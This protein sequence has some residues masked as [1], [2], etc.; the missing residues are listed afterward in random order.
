MFVAQLKKSLQLDLSWAL[1][2]DPR[3]RKKVL[4]LE[5][6]KIGNKQV[7]EEIKKIFI[8]CYESYESH[9]LG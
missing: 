9:K 2:I 7:S 1:V 6:G 4:A 3:M 5:D 8:F